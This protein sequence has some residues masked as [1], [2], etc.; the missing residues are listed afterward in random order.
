MAQQ[1]KYFV[2]EIFI[3]VGKQTLLQMDD[4]A[5]FIFF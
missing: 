2:R 4:N 5:F 3:V 1:I